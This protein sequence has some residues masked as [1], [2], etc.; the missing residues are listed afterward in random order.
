[1]ISQSEWAEWY[2]G[3]IPAHEE[4]VNAWFASGLKIMQI[5][6]DMEKLLNLLSR[7]S[8][9]GKSRFSVEYETKN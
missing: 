1:M 8:T 5:S 6:A 9:D 7:H 2:R 3:T 4:F